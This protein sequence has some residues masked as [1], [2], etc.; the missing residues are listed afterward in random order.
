MPQHDQ[1]HSTVQLIEAAQLTPTEH[2]IWKAF[3]NEAVDPE[4]A[5]RY[6]WERVHA[7]P[8]SPEKALREL[9][10]LWKQVALKCESRPMVLLYCH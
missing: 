8:G 2:L 10:I 6:I 5:A 1:Y 7:S 9:K 4:H 3:L